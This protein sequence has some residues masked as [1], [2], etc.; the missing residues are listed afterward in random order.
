MDFSS[1]KAVLQKAVGDPQTADQILGVIRASLA[2]VDPYHAVRDALRR[3]GDALWLGEE[4]LDLHPQTRVT[5]VSIGKAAGAMAR[6]AVDALGDRVGAGV[7]VQKVPVGAEAGRLPPVFRVFQGGHPVP[8]A[9]SLD[10]GRFIS[11]LL[12]DQKESDLALCLISGGGSALMTYPHEGVSLDDLQDLT[13]QLLSCG[14]RIDE[15]NTIRKHLDR[16][17]GGGLARAAHPARLVSLV[18]SDVVGDPLDMVASGP[19]V[20]DPTTFG[21]ACQILEKYDLLT[22]APPAIV[23]RLQ[24]GADGDLPETPGEEDPIFERV[25]TRVVGNNARAAQAGVASA[26]AAGF[27][28]QL[29]TTRLQGDARQAGRFLGAILHQ[30]GRTGQPLARPACL[31]AGG[32]TTVVVQ[33]DG[34]GGRNLEVALAAAREIAGLEKTL[35]IS[36]AT[37]GDDGPTGAA[38][39]VVTGQTIHRASALGL[40]P[41]DFLNR[42]DTYH[43]FE[44]LDA[45]IVT[46]PTGTNVNDLYFL[47]AYV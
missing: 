27:S 34:L 26:R 7:V 3:E 43:F 5:V 20:P 39:A 16:V 36:L 14:A 33:G 21:D 42:N 9:G 1:L 10:A 30:M 22:K 2:A 38:G 19:T 28:S 13:Q 44:P 29:L 40:D 17:K 18:L 41:L 11:R 8:N 35:F 32:E 47:V 24:R 12:A 4:R 31:V 23:D 45:L 46:G 37:D 15:I 25:Q 6:A